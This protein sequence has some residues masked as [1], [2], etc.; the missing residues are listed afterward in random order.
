MTITGFCLPENASQIRFHSGKLYA[1]SGQ[2]I[3]VHVA[4]TGKQRPA[5]YTI[6]NKFSNFQ[7]FPSFYAHLCAVP[8]NFNC[9]GENRI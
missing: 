7:C 3:E 2:S 5:I 1:F 4:H 8:I 6:H 9:N